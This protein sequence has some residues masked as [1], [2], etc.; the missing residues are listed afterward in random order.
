MKATPLYPKNLE[1]L[2]LD[3]RHKVLINGAFDMLHTG[4]IDLFMHAK[5][6]DPK[7][8]V[9][10]ALDSDERIRQNKGSDRPVNRLEVRAK[11]LSRII[12]IDEVWTFNSDL[13]LIWLMSRADVRLIGSDWRGKE[14]VGEGLI[15]VEYFER[16]NDEATTNTIENYINRRN[17]LG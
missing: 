11:I 15:D 6:L 4:H 14:I 12:D 1:S 2:C 13:E 16:T 3:H 5:S 9:I 8:H 17:L 7:A 10:C